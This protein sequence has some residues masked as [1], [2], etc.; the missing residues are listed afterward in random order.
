MSN[1]GAVS[2]V[3]SGAKTSYI[4]PAGYHNGKGS[5]SID[6]ETKAATPT[7]EAQDIVPTSGKVLTK[8]TVNAIPS[9]YGDT[10]DADAVADD[11]LAGKIAVTAVDGVATK[12]TGTM[13]DNGTVTKVLDATTGNQSQTIAAGK[14]SGSGRVSIVL[15][16]KS[17][18]PTT[19]AQTI[20]PTAG[21]V[22][23]KVSVAAIPAK[24][25]DVTTATGVAAD[26][27]A[28]KIVFGKNASGAAVKITGTMANNGSTGGTIDGLTTTS[29]TIPAGYTS[30]GTVTLSNAIETALAAI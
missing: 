6:V 29:Y 17:T 2:Q 14:H 1:N 23:S 20:T 18:T 19:A 11:L 16:E 10:T 28:G 26:V 24:F 4:I 22:L 5:V 25:G 12:I 27:L 9:K 7:E 3:L 30:G 21:K 13:A 8:V 15:E